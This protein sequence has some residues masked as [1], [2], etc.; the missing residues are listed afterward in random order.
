MGMAKKY[1]RHVTVSH[2][3]QNQRHY[4][5]LQQYFNIS[6]IIPGKISVITARSETETKSTSDKS[7]SSITSS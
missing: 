4:Y 1:C 7:A 6:K 2:L 3:F 5:L